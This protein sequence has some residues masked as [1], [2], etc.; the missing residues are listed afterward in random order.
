MHAPPPQILNSHKYVLALSG[1][2]HKPSL[3]LSFTSHNFGP[4]AVWR[5]GMTPC[6]QLLTLANTD[7]QPIAVDPQLEGEVAGMAR[8]RVLMRLGA[9]RVR[10]HVRHRLGG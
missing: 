2:G 10:S 7:T 1:T 6:V 4:C 9:Q 5:P 3:S 8:S